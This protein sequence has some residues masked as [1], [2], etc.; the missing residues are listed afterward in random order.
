LK[1]VS[2]LR[3]NLI[4]VVTGTAL[5]HLINLIS[6]PILARI[7]APEV[8]GNYALFLSFCSIFIS[9]ITLR[10]E[11]KLHELK[12]DR[13]FLFVIY[14]LFY[15][16]IISILI[17]G[18]LLSFILLDFLGYSSLSLKVVPIAFIFFMGN[19][20]FTITRYLHLNANDYDA[21]AKLEVGKSVSRSTTQLGFG[22][23]ASSGFSLAIG[24]AISRLFPGLVQVRPF[25]NDLKKA[26]R[27]FS[28][29]DSLRTFKRNIGYSAKGFFST[30]VNALNFA[31]VIPLLTLVFSEEVAGEY[32]MMYRLLALPISLLSLAI[33]DT[34]Q[35][36]FLKS[37]NKGKLI[38]K[39]VLRLTIVSF[40]IFSAVYALGVPI[41]QIILGD[42]W[43]LFKQMIRP[44]SILFFFSFIV[45]P[46]SRVLFLIDKVNLKLIYDLIG[47]CLVIGVLWYTKNQD[48]TLSNC[49]WLL[50]STLAIN[51]IIYLGIILKAVHSSKST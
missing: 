39:Y 23:M 37:E 3:S 11:F 1:L 21:I 25:V 42:A 4:K 41:F 30:V 51:Y 22:L 45:S 44:L 19:A 10:L 43:T 36:A 28:L 24:D 50:S 29:R 7:Y 26:I 12:N 32:S 47:F 46:I 49:M 40:I 33:A 48:L 35:N 8:Y 34:F 5:G 38:L 18:L 9:S 6:V 13:V 2:F 27:H 17:S 31:M 16:S 15:S 20:L 14:V